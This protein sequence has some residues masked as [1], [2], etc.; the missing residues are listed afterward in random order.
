VT[1]SVYNIFAYFLYCNH[2]VHRDF[3]ITLC[4]S[5]ELFRKCPVIE[6]KVFEVPKVNIWQMVDALE[7][8]LVDGWLNCG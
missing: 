8:Q 5:L 1:E 7:L 3:L 2:Q 6:G 4:I